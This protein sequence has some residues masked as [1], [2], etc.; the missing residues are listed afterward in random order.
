MFY[1]QFF[2]GIGLGI[3]IGIEEGFIII[4]GTLLCIHYHIELKYK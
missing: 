1:A 3:T 4:T 2:K